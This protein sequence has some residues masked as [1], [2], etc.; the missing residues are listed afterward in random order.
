MYHIKFTILAFFLKV[1]VETG[2]CCVALAGL[3]LM[4]SFLSLSVLG[5]QE[6]PTMPGHLTLYK[7]SAQ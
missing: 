7:F 1:V 5:L 2:C 4:I 6:F 3:E